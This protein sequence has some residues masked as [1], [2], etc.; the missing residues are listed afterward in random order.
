[1]WDFVLWD[2]VR[3]DFVLWDFVLWDFV[4]WD[5]VRIPHEVCTQSVSRTNVI[6]AASLNDVSE[7]MFG[8]LNSVQEPV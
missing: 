8:A 5:S 3:R 7:Q 6:T 1:M 2:F 4:L